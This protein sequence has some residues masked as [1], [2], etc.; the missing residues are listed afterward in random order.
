MD[1]RKMS[2]DDIYGYLGVPVRLELNVNDQPICGNVYTIDPESRSVVIMQFEKDKK[3]MPHKLLWV[4]GSAIKLM[5][6]L[7]DNELL[8][9]C[10]PCTSESIE[11]VDKLIQG[12]VAPVQSTEDESI[13][14][15]R[16]KRLTAFLTSKHVPFIKEEA[17]IRIGPVRLERP[18]RAENLLSDNA[19]ALKRTQQMLADVLK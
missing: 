17:L 4:S 11:L 12:E 8:T 15:E 9:G 16:L 18:Y 13:V 1:L 6:E 2:H 14:E 19:L 5:H 7:D 3:G 10:V